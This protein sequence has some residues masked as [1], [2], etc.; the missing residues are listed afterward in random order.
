MNK[1]KRQIKPRQP[2]GR[3]AGVDRGLEDAIRETRYRQ[4]DPLYHFR[5]FD[6]FTALLAA[7]LADGGKLDFFIGNLPSD[8]HL[9]NADISS[10]FPFN[11]DLDGGSAH[12]FCDGCL[13]HGQTID[14]EEQPD[15]SGMAMRKWFI[16]GSRLEYV[17]KDSRALINHPMILIP[18]GLGI[19]GAKA[20]TVNDVDRAIAVHG[21][22]HPRA[23][24]RFGGPDTAETPQVEAE[25]KH[26]AHLWFTGDWITQLQALVDASTPID[27]PGPLKLGVVIYGWSYK[28]VT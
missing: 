10:K 20:T 15:Y 6:T 18:P 22:P 28:P 4:W 11:Y 13:P 16:E 17:I 26:R 21:V 24:Y 8:R 1:L 14:E 7:V 12:W 5:T 25:D 3:I 27:A 23:Y 9:T 19:S 2:G